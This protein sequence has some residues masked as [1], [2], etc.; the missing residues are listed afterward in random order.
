MTKLSIQDVSLKD[1]KVLM[2]VD[3]NVP[4][5]SNGNIT[6]DSRIRASLPSIEYILN[7][8]ASLI[9]LSHL[10][11]PKGKDPKYS[12]SPCAKRLSELLNRPVI[13]APDCIGEKV[14]SLVENLTA[15]D[16][17]LLENLRYY[18]AEQHPEKDPSFAKRLASYGDIYVNDAFGA[19]H[20][21]HSSIV[22][23]AKLFQQKAVAGFL[24][25]KEV[26]FLGAVAHHPKRP[27]YAVLGGA[28]VSTKL[29]VIQNL[30]DQVDG[31]FIG[32]GMA[33]TFLKAQG[34]EIGN[35]IF[36]QDNIESVKDVIKKCVDKAV[37]LWLPVDIVITKELTNDSEKKVITVKEGIPEGWMGADIGPKTVLEWS[38]ALGQ[39][40]TVFWNGPVGVFELP[41]LAKGTEG[42]AKTLAQLP[43][44]TIIGGGDSIAAVNKMHLADKFTHLSTGGGASLEYLEFGHLPGIDALCDR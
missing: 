9:L 12:L 13:M 17:L 40:S 16:I 15:G 33:Y 18:E 24:L 26:A 44:T 7:Q 14:E 28:K 23:L 32:G 10:G 25:D 43:A 3:F 20:R 31:L 34:M 11:R 19:A 2:R 27:F 41:S 21:N 4:L 30:I 36:D 6:D 22:P 39:A 29:G 5:D 42:I 35:S 8:G 38:Q 37:Q 1:L